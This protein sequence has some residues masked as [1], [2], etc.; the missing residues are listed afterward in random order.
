MRIAPPHKV[1]VRNPNFFRN[2]N[3]I[4][5]TTRP[6]EWATYSKW[7][8]LYAFT[9]MLPRRFRNEFFNFYGKVLQGNQAPYSRSDVCVQ[10]TET[11][12]KDAVGKLYVDRAFK[13]ADKA[14]S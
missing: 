14:G 13:A 4:L 1:N 6:E 10:L 2:L 9:P 12:L 11:N 8:L 3:E 5:R 7:Q